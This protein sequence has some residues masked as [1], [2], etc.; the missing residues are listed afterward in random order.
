MSVSEKCPLPTPR[1]LPSEVGLEAEE[2][3]RLTRGYPSI[4][5][6]IER[7]TSLLENL[8]AE[9]RPRIILLVGDW[10]EGKT[11][12]YRGI[13]KR[14]YCGEKLAC[15]ELQASEL[16]RVVSRL[17]GEPGVARGADLLVWGVACVHLHREC[18]SPA[19]DFEE[20]VESLGIDGKPILVFIDEFEDV[21]ARLDD[22]EGL[23]TVL[24]IVEG[25]TQLANGNS[26]LLES[27]GLL[28]S[29]HVMI[30]V[31]RSAYHT[32]ST[33]R[34]LA[35]IIPRL[36]RRADVVEL[37][38]LTLLESIHLFGELLR[39]IFSADVAVT[40]VARPPTL[41]NP[42]VSASM[43]IPGALE[44]VAGSL[45]R[46]L[47]VGCRSGARRLEPG[48]A[49]EVYESIEVTIEAS[50]EKILIPDE[51][52][53]EERECVRRLCGRGCRDPEE[54]RRAC[55]LL[56]L[57]GAGVQ[58]VAI[59]DAVGS[60]DAWLRLTTPG[61]AGRC[62]YYHIRVDPV[63]LLDEAAAA[64]SALMREYGT[65]IERV[66]GK[67]AAPLQ[68]YRAALDPY[69]CIGWDG[70]TGF[71]IPVSLVDEYVQRLGISHSE[72]SAL[73]D[74]VEKLLGALEERGV[75]EA[76]GDC[77]YVPFSRLTR[78]IFSHEL[79]LLS[80]LPRERRLEA[81]RRVSRELQP[82]YW[83]PPLAALLLRSLSRLLPDADASTARLEW[84]EEGKALI[85]SISGGS[86]RLSLNLGASIALRARR[87]LRMLVVAGDE[88]DDDELRRIIERLSAEKAPH[89][90][91]L[92]HI[93][94]PGSRAT[95]IERLYHM[96]VVS[97]GVTRSAALQL[98]AIGWEAGE[99]GVSYDTLAEYTIRVLEGARL[100]PLPGFT[101]QLED[102]LHRL[103]TSLRLD[104][105]NDEARR[106]L[107]QRGVLLPERLE[108]PDGSIASPEDAR[109]AALWLT[110]YPYTYDAPIEV[111]RIYEAIDDDVRRYMLF[112]RRYQELIGKDI[113]SP[114]E[115]RKEIL[116]LYSLKLID[117]STAY[118]LQRVNLV[119]GDS[120]YY[121]RLRAYAAR[122]LPLEVLASLVIDRNTDFAS[123]KALLEALYALGLLRK[124]GDGW[125][126]VNEED[127]R[128]ELQKL[129]NSL[130]ALK[131]SYGDILEKMAVH[132]YGKERGF[133]VAWGW[134]LLERIEERVN[135]AW[136]QLSAGRLEE[137]ARLA[138]AASR[139]L[140]SLLGD[141]V[142]TQN[143]HDAKRHLELAVHADRE[144]RRLLRELD[145]ALAMLRDARGRL[146]R[147]L[148]EYVDR[149]RRV[150][151]VVELE[152]RLSGAVREATRLQQSI[153]DENAAEREAEKLWRRME[154][155]SFPF[156]YKQ[157]A[158]YCYNL[159]LYK[160]KEELKADELAQAARELA[161]RMQGY[162]AEI[163][164]YYEELHARVN[165]LRE[166]LEKLSRHPVVGPV[167]SKLSIPSL[168]V[169]RIDVE[170]VIR[171]S[172]VNTLIASIGS[173]VELWKHE[174]DRISP[175][176]VIERLDELRRSADEALTAL[177][178]QRERI[179]K[180]RE[181]VASAVESCGGRRDI[182]EVL[183]KVDELLNDAS[184]LIES[185][186][187]APRLD[188]A[189]DAR[190]AERMLEEWLK[191]VADAVEKSR[192]RLVE[193]EK[194]LED[195]WQ[196]LRAELGAIYGNIGLAKAIARLVNAPDVAAKAEE[197]ARELRSVE[198]AGPTA[199]P[200]LCKLLARLGEGRVR[201]LV[202][203]ILRNAG[204]ERVEA[205]LV[206][207]LVQRRTL[208][209]S[210]IRSL[211][212]EL[213][214]PVEEVLAALSRLAEKGIVDVRIEPL[215]G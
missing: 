111:R 208:K 63:T 3:L 89:L 183:A 110:L 162:A 116:A 40:D 68:V 21:V 211:A 79:S 108:R 100:G 163:N 35:T 4:R 171:V 123:L 150:S 69:A 76:A 81:W 113:E 39:S 161:E 146:E 13:V 30:A 28:N 180:L 15:A 27:R 112:G 104:T 155:R 92:V 74:L 49:R 57:S 157:G 168:A 31:S 86:A 160:L 34:E 53:A 61:I 42:M 212:S 198:G 107:E 165:T 197:I 33:R 85:A 141:R 115:L 199:L 62:R 46:S 149:N 188:A 12:I 19:S 181:V 84:V 45:A 47:T 97:I 127:V 95:D 71:C 132:V 96:P 77:L 14:D 26:P 201:E 29:F 207:R 118:G 105:V 134:R 59:A 88:V 10:G 24:E 195:A 148:R 133:R 145:E 67:N 58:P 190:D 130:N 186:E 43:G 109:Y 122:P 51:Y 202:E 44:H 66:V 114:D 153:I 175:K 38:R 174:N 193:A 210:D 205:E 90:T 178:E 140:A 20:F 25:L 41:L 196:R 182:L 173:R 159:K 131:A 142:Y 206:K 22:P 64:L 143:C 138:T 78:Y 137:A 192:A 2:R 125:R 52:A 164:R 151:V 54:A 98:A 6:V 154:G 128:S 179:T 136:G 75:V 23:R 103:Y 158:R 9:Q 204:L 184:S 1:R 16:Y 166:M 167:A 60:P 7:V 185:V 87:T 187:E 147:A 129:H 117:V 203:T 102:A 32:L 65:L 91:I 11:S 169:Q 70:G 191:R 72:A 50:R 209:W 73:Q 156:Y 177:R 93:G 5:P 8:G 101:E 200:E 56:L 36:F 189:R 215:T 17:V 176:Q 119:V 144:Y 152:D 37:S 99:A 83:L 18:R 94:G 170:D 213:G 106:R 82:R 172:D 214:V 55:S 135:A 126:I 48:N 194:L 139:M 121:Q 124:E 80:F 120:P